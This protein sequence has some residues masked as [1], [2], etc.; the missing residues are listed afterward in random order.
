MTGLLGCTRNPTTV[1]REV[2]ARPRLEQ[3]A[4]AAAMDDAYNRIDFGFVDGKDV[5]VETKSLA[6]TDVDFI[7]AFVQKRVLE[8]GGSPVLEPDEAELRL[9]STMEVSGTDEVEKIGK[10]VVMGQFKGTL[11]VVN[12][13]DGA[14][15]K[16]FELDS[17]AQTKRNRKGRTRIVRH[18]PRPPADPK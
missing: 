15:L 12:L 14:V 16:I 5:Y 13:A 4:L 9:T 2:S 6:K 11:Q 17:L 10:D 7:T 1:S 18:T 8:G 3:L